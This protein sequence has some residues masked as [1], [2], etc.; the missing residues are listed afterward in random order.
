VQLVLAPPGSKICPHCHVV[1]PRKSHVVT[2]RV[3]VAGSSLPSS[4]CSSCDRKRA[5]ARYRTIREREH[6][7]VCSHCK[8]NLG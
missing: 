4:G 8:R 1:V 6:Y 7:W 2:R 3:R 5:A